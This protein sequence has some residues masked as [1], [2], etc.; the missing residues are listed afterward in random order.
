MKGIGRVILLILSLVGFLSVRT[1]ASTS[2]QSYF[3]KNSVIKSLQPRYSSILFTQQT[4]DSISVEKDYSVKLKD[5]NMALLYA[6]IP[7]IVV[8]GAGHF[9]ADKPAAGL[10]LLGVEGIGLL[11]VVRESFSQSENNYY[12]G[13][14]GFNVV[15]GITLFFGS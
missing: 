8:H 5:P 13:G 11:F 6:F 2:T 10:V 1:Y 9:Y 7:G 14:S 4:Q 15:A 12:S 3:F